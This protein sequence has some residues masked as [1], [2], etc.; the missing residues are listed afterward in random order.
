[1]KYAL[2]V[3]SLAVITG[4]L[5]MSFGTGQLAS[6]VKDVS[7]GKFPF[8]PDATPLLIPAPAMSEIRISSVPR[9]HTNLSLH[10]DTKK[11]LSKSGLRVYVFPGS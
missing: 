9:D 6:T 8:Q 3:L 1:M 7:P 4:L 5:L 11:N 10:A 2:S